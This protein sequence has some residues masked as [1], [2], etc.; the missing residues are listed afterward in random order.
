MLP[1]LFDDKLSEVLS[2]KQFRYLKTKAEH[3]YCLIQQEAPES[4]LIELTDLLQVVTEIKSIL[5]DDCE[6][7]TNTD[8]AQGS[9]ATLA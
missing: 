1:E 9:M 4:V 3:A 2:E 6:K 8:W 7:K 5:L